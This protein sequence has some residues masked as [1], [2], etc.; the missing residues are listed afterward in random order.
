MKGILLFL[1]LSII[2]ESISK[3]LP[4]S[5]FSNLFHLKSGQNTENLYLK[6]WLNKL[7]I[8]LPND[9][10][11]NATKGYIEDLLFIIYL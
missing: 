10:I 11:K 7:T 3:N 9:L 1:I 6:E 5:M 8:D 4:Y 2:T